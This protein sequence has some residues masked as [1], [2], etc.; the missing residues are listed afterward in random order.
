MNNSGEYETIDY[1]AQQVVNFK[2]SNS[3]TVPA[4]ALIVVEGIDGSGKSTQ[5]HLLDAWL[6]HLGLRVYDTGWN[7]SDLVKE[8][9][10]K[11]KKKALLTPTTFSLLHATDFADRYERNVFPLLR[12]GY[13]VLADRYIYTAFARDTVRGCN[14]KWVRKIYDF[15]IRPNVT[16]YFDVSVDLAVK[17]IMIGRPKLKYYEAGM[18]LN[19]SNDIYESYR[20][21]QSRIIE[22]YRKMA[23]KE[24]FYVMDGTLDI[25]AQ[26]KKMR[27]AVL[28]LL[29][30]EVAAAASKEL[31]S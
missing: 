12:A 29:P 7:S 10:S 1:E 13:F 20:I 6:K 18:D 22:Q 31:G 23:A 27:R 14:P 21:F 9:T 19:L 15:A 17:R 30:P 5:L 16:F 25:E 3:G 26:Q 4:G 24:D 28:P 11:G 8:I 2:R